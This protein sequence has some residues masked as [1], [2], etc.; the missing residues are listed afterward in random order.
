MVA[1][2]VT[3][4]T[5]VTRGVELRRSRVLVSAVLLV[6]PVLLLV[7]A[8]LLL[9]VNASRRRGWQ[10]R[11]RQGR[12]RQ[13]QRRR[14]E[15]RWQQRGSHDGHAWGRGRHQLSRRRCIRRDHYQPGHG[16]CHW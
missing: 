14:R 1:V 3:V 4:L 10:G 16:E 11:G 6:V 5:R 15:W 9:L 2:L 7:A 8:V 12:G 13:R